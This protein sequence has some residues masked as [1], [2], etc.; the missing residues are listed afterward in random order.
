MGTGWFA[1]AYQ[2]R[3]GPLSIKRGVESFRS[4]LLRE[5]NALSSTRRLAIMDRGGVIS[6]T[7]LQLDARLSQ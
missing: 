6:P 3:L 4:L 5:D 2:A 1:P 7:Y